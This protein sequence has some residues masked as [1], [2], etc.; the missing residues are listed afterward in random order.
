MSVQGITGEW[1]FSPLFG[2]IS[3]KQHRGHIYRKLTTV[4]LLATI[5]GNFQLV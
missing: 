2:I 5:K 1:L 4:N 3:L